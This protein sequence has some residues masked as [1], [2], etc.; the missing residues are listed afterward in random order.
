[1]TTVLEWGHSQFVARRSADA[2][3]RATNVLQEDAPVAVIEMR[4]IVTSTSYV[5]ACVSPVTLDRERPACE[6]R[7]TRHMEA[8]ASSPLARTRRPRHSS[9]S[10]TFTCS[11]PMGEALMT[12]PHD[13]MPEPDRPVGRWTPAEYRPARRS[14][15]RPTALL[16]T[17]T[18]PTVR[19][20]SSVRRMYRK[21][22]DLPLRRVAPDSQVT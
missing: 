12:A 16:A 11:V 21:A 6:Q 18:L 15:S 13:E 19:W 4:A 17:A 5:D 9:G 2:M 14:G 3:S 1:M 8:H 22:M 7:M 10:R 20:R